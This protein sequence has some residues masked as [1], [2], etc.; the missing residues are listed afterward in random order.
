M[1]APQPSRRSSRAKIVRRWAVAVTADTHIPLQADELHERLTG[2]LDD[3]LDALTSDPFT[4]DPAFLCGVQLVEMH[5][6]TAESIRSTMDALGAGLAAMP[7]LAGLS[8]RT[9]RIFSTLGAMAAGYSEAT[10]QST[11]A[12]Q[13]AVHRA[14]LTA[15]GDVHRKLRDV[16]AE[17]DEVLNGCTDG[18]ALI[19]EDGRFIRANAAFR[20]VLGYEPKEL[21]D[22]TLFSVVPPE[23]AGLFRSLLAGGTRHF[24]RKQQLIGKDQQV[25]WTKLTLSRPRQ[26]GFVIVFEDR[27]ELE[28]LQSRVNHMSLHDMLTGLPNRQYFT[29]RLETALPRGVTLCQLDIDGFAAI[30]RGLGRQIGDNVLM[31]VAQRLQT[32]VAADDTMVARFGPDEF[33]VLMPTTAPE[34]IVRHLQEALRQP[35]EVSGHHIVLSVAIGVV[36]AVGS[37]PGDA[38][39][40]AELALARAQRLGPGQ[41]SLFGPQDREHAMA[42]AVLPTALQ[43]GQVAVHYQPLHRLPGKQ[44]VGF[45]AELSWGTL[46][47]WDCV[48]RAENWLLRTVCS[49]GPDL[50]V[51]V[52]V[53]S[54]DPGE[55]KRIAAE[56]GR[57]LDRLCLSVRG[58]DQLLPLA[59]TGVGIEIRDFDLTDLAFLEALPIKAVRLDRRMRHPGALT[60]KAL[61]HV[62]TVVRSVGA[63][64]IV[65]GLPSWR[66]AERWRDLGADIVAV[67]QTGR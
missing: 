15:L 20:E 50:P 41:W 23:D 59:D 48:K 26:A 32:A 40:A 38:L 56:T 22:K 39:D 36:N 8:R 14:S 24:E 46:S 51:H 43:T 3:L 54:P 60:T 7:E 28:L 19:K 63:S 33:A 30:T 35:I 52:G 27:T 55:V 10:R 29:T 17:L 58:G 57:E 16:S 12:Q 31:H 4:P 13:E 1:T 49:A 9:E 47:H 44:R 61:R 37:D 11:F 53:N 67:D 65:D 21:T 2:L 62:L 42:A 25:S 6:G 64:V 34:L 66:E 5:C 18:V 45:D